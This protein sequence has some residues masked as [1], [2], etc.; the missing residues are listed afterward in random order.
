[1]IRWIKEYLRSIHED[2]KKME[3]LMAYLAL[4]LVILVLIRGIFFS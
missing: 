2:K 1:M 4:I 3:L